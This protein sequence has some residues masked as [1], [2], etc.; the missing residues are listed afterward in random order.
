MARTPRLH[1]W[2]GDPG[3]RCDVCY[4]DWNGVFI[5]GIT[6]GGKWAN[7]CT[8]CHRRYGHGLGTGK[9]QRYEKQPD[10]RWLKTAG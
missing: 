10:G 7:M 6:Q 3:K 2:T 9:G 1:Y 8:E 4:Q 5:D